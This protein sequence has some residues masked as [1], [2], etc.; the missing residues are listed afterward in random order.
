MWSKPF[1]SFV[2]IYVSPHVRKT[3]TPRDIAHR[4]PAI[5]IHPA[6]TRENSLA[7]PGRQPAQKLPA[8]DNVKYD[9][10]Q[11]GEKDRRHEARDVNPVL[12]P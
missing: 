7:E 9:D 3:R 4:V 1:T 2:V 10:R 12:S 6:R 8:G 11:H 5:L